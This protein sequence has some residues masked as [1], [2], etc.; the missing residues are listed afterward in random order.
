MTR[1]PRTETEVK[2]DICKTGRIMYTRGFV[3]ASQGNLS[4]RIGSD[5]ILVTPAGARKSQLTPDDLV[6]T[7]LTGRV[8]CGSGRP[9]SEIRM[10]LLY[11]R[12]RPDVRA[13]C[14]AHPPTAT[15][16]AAA[17]RALE[18]PVLPEVVV[19]LGSIPLAA[20]GTPG[21]SDLCASLQSLVRGY[22][23]ILLENHG[24]VTCGPTLDM[25]Y[26]RLEIVEQFARI[27]LVAEYLGGPRILS[28]SD[29]RTLIAARPRYGAVRA[30]NGLDLLPT[31]DDVSRDSVRNTNNSVSLL[32]DARRQR[33]PRVVSGHAF[34]CVAVARTQSKAPISDCS[35]L[36]QHP[37][38]TPGSKS[39][40][41]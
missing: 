23:A 31:G 24:V 28:C 26:Q 11:Y 19:G 1:E 35:E 8:V 17:G 37:R 40:S 3:V 2:R 15:G 18:Q 38:K 20:Y 30:T 33:G 22:D 32:N 29:V 10:H 41:T 4:V 9:S 16:F 6:L 21:T 14:H 27:L 34:C 36:R 5:R 25:A 13:V 12:A 39:F 7:D